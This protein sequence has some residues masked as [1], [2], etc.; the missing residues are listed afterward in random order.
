VRILGTTDFVPSHGMAGIL[1]AC[2]SPTPC[3]IAA[4]I[5]VGGVTIANTGTEQI[6]GEE[7]GYVFFSI[8][9]RGRQLLAGTLGN[10]LPADLSLAAG[11][12]VAHGTIALVGFG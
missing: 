5:K 3:H 12:S 11:T 9:G 2:A 10:H 7:A 4:T 8:S 6:G 1:A